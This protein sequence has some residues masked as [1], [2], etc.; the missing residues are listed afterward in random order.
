[1]SQNLRALYL[2]CRESAE[3][4]NLRQ[5]WGGLRELQELQL[6]LVLV[7]TSNRTTTIITTIIVIA[8]VA[9]ARDRGLQ[10]QGLQAERLSYC[11][12]RYSYI[13]IHIYTYVCMYIYIYILFL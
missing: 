9:G 12:Y 1:M 5:L 11:Y 10:V 6:L 2:D 4:T 3:L 13:Y 7:T 8:T